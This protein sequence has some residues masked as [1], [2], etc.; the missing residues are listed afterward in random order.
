MTAQF[1]VDLNLLGKSV[2][3]YWGWGDRVA[4]VVVVV[5]VVMVVVGSPIH[6]RAVLFVWRYVTVSPPAGTWRHDGA[7]V[8]V[9]S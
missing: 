3:D 8:C 6:F 5:V 1:I 9:M 4:V 7:T 2:C